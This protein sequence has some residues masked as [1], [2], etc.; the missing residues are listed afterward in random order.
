MYR[1]DIYFICKTLAEAPIFIIVP[2]LFTT[3]AYPMIGLYPGVEHFFITAGV[4]TL[5]ANVATS[6]G[7]YINLINN[8][9]NCFLKI[10]GRITSF[11]YK[12]DI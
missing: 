1:T 12:Y 9:E 5:I 6:F 11:L 3:I 2:M 7:K 4:I 8:L 10:Y